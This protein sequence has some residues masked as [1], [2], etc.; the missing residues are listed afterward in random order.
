MLVNILYFCSY[1]FEIEFLPGLYQS[2][3]RRIFLI[4]LIVSIASTKLGCRATS[5]VLLENLRPVLLIGLCV[6]VWYYIIGYFLIILFEYN[7]KRAN[8]E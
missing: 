8:S 6:I 2:T 4:M 5:I 7:T 1:T 3:G